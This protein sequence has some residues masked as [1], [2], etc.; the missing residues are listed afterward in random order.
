MK[1][2]LVCMLILCPMFVWAQ[3]DGT[4]PKTDSQLRGSQGQQRIS[5]RGSKSLFGRLQPRVTQ[6]RVASPVNNAKIDVV[7][8]T[9]TE[10]EKRSIEALEKL[11]GES[12]AAKWGL[13]EI[14]IRSDKNAQWAKQSPGPDYRLIDVDLNKGAGGDFI[15]LHA[16]YGQISRPITDVMIIEGDKA[17]APPG[18]EKINKDLNRGAGGAFLYLAYRRDPNGIPITGLHVLEG[19][20]PQ[21]PPGWRILPTDLNK[22]A[23]GAFLYLIYKK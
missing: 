18:W 21:V 7:P 3:D 2:L 22:G 1:K 16:A 4:T 17:P 10:E 14:F 23:K 13:V 15:Y 20:N 9:V 19:N 8:A 12:R 11:A 6:K 5:P